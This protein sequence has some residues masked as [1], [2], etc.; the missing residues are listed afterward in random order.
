MTADILKRSL[1]VM[2]LLQ[3]YAHLYAFI[4]RQLPVLQLLEVRSKITARNNT[5]DLARWPSLAVN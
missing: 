2:K 1:D 3:P 4:P 5:G